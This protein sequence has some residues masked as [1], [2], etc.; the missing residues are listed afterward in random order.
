MAEIISIKR[1][2]EIRDPDIF[3]DTVLNDPARLARLRAKREEYLEQI[4]KEAEQEE[5]ERR[6]CKEFADSALKLAAGFSLFVATLATYV[7]LVF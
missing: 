5:E 2:K 3:I 6:E 1:M 4:Q 7:V